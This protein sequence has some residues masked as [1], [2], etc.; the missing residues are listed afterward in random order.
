MRR[1]VELALK[2]AGRTHP[3]P[4][5]GCVLVNID[6]EVVGEGWHEKAGEPHAEVMALRQAE[7]R[8]QG[9]TAY[10]TLE[11]CNHHGRTPPCTLALIK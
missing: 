1:A 10:V 6:G 11:P 5:V 2:S 8:A 7:Q 4:C 3:N 9:C